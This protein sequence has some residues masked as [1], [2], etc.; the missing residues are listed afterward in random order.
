M[1]I[2][3][4]EN[5][6]GVNSKEGIIIIDTKTMCEVIKIKD[7]Q[8]NNNEIEKIVYISSKYIILKY[9]SDKFLYKVIFSEEEI[10]I[11]KIDF[12]SI[13][14]ISDSIEIDN[15]NYFAI[16]FQEDLYMSGEKRMFKL[17]VIDTMNIDRFGT[18]LHAIESSIT[19]LIHSNR[20][21]VLF[22]FHSNGKISMWEI[23]K[24]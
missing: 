15:F 20:D 24:K 10:K 3:I 16:A 5:L 14:Y 8:I 4:Y 12:T 6:I 1:C 7:W 17:K 9:K 23:I 21:G 22:S 18:Y 11:E 13:E 19:K 2:N